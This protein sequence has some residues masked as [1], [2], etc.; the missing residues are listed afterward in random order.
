MKNR[1]QELGILFSLLLFC[2]GAWWGLFTMKQDVWKRWVYRPTFLAVFIMVTWSVVFGLRFGA[3]PLFSFFASREFF[4][5][6]LCPAIYLMWHAGLDIKTLR[7][8]CWAAIFMLMLNYLFF[9][10]TM[11]LEAA[12]FSPEPTVSSLVTLDSWRGFRLKPPLYGIM[13]GIL[14]SIM[15]IFSGYSKRHTFAAIIVFTT[16][17]YI[18]SIVQFRSTL[19]TMLLSSLAYYFITAH[20]NRLPLLWSAIASGLVVVPILVILL[21][22]GGKDEVEQGEVDAVRAEAFAAAF[23]SRKERPLWGVGKASAYSI[24]YQDLEFPK[25]FPDDIGLVG[26]TYIYGGVGISIYLYFHFMILYRLW[27]TNWQYKE[28]VGKHE[29]L[30]WGIFIWMCAQ[31]L[32]LVLNPGLA[33]G[34]G[35]TIASI[36]LALCAIYRH[37][38]HSGRLMREKEQLKYF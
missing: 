28:I 4:F 3:N 36:G 29:P 5:I 8:V 25:F 19:A 7:R 10:F 34:K 22:S 23:E 17:A 33:Y 6:F 9:Y 14:M 32:N 26:M 18:W 11:D 12:F 30:I 24:T 37:M 31:T 13:V 2:L 16:G 21:N 20:Y 27:S 35:I 1:L 38:L 15:M